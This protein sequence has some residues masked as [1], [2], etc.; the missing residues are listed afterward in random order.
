MT[1]PTATTNRRGVI[2][3]LS[4]FHRT[5]LIFMVAAFVS[6]VLSVA[7]WFLVDR[8]LGLFVGLWVPAI[9]SL[10]TLVLTGERS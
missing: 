9:H 5:K 1:T 4:P 8:E 6:F 3:A 10:G 7:L 2:A